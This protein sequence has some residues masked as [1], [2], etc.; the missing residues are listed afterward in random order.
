[1]RPFLVLLLNES[2]KASSPDTLLRVQCTDKAL[3]NGAQLHSI[4]SARIQPK[5]YCV[6]HS[7]QVSLIGTTV[8]EFWAFG[9]LV[10]I[11]FYTFSYSVYNI[12]DIRG[13]S[14]IVM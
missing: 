13:P 5:T 8:A 12:M 9:S 11:A 1:M 10:G 6:V 7:V 2:L 14:I 4:S 3:S